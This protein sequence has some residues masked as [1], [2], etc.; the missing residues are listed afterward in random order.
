MSPYIVFHDTLREMACVRPSTPERLR[1]IYGVSDKKLTEL[2][3][4]FLTVIKEH[5]ARRGLALDCRSGPV[6]APPPVEVTAQHKAVFQLFQQG[7]S[8]EDV[9]QKQNYKAMH[10]HG[11]PG[12]YILERKPTSIETWCRCRYRRIQEASRQGTERLK[13]IYSKRWGE[14]VPY[15]EI[16]LVARIFKGSCPQGRKRFTGRRGGRPLHPT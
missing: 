12:E 4:R 3:P 10:R 11:V 5:C 14:E 13:P 2:G 16:R 9:M 15:D 1:M 6:A 7:A 8:I